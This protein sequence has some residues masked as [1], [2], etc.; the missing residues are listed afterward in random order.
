MAVIRFASSFSWRCTVECTGNGE[1]IWCWASKEMV[2][3]GS[4][5]VNQMSPQVGQEGASQDWW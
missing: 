3:V 4:E 5:V 1:K 2:V